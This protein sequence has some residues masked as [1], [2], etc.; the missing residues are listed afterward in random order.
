MNR[1]HA[2]TTSVVI[3]ALA[4][5]L[6]H[7]QGSGDSPREVR[8]RSGI[9]LVRIPA[10]SFEMGSNIRKAEQPIHR[11]TIREFWLGATEVTQAQWQAVMGDNPS[12]FT[13]AG[14]DAPVEM[15]T[16]DAAQVFVQKLG[17]IDPDWT[18]RLPSEAEWEYACRAG[19]NAE[20]YGPAQEVAWIREN[21]GGTTHPVGQKR[22]NAFG[23][24]DILG[25]VQE[26]VQDRWFE[27]HTGAPADGRAR[28]GGTSPLHPVKGGGWDLPEFFL[29]TALRDPLAPVHRLGLRVAAIPRKAAARLGSAP[30]LSIHEAERVQLLASE[31]QA[32]AQAEQ[33]NRAKDLFLATLS[34]ELRTPLSTMLMSAQILRQVA[35]EDPRIERASASIERSANAQARLIDELL[36]VS[37]IVSGKLLLD[38][39][40]VDLAVVVHEAV[41]GARPAAQAKSLMLEADIDDEIGAVY[42]DAS[43]L[44]QV[45]NNLLV[46]AI[47]FTPHDGRV[48][49]RLERLGD[50]R[51]Q[52]AV[53][54]TGVGIHPEVLP[55]VFSR[56]VQA[57]STVTR[58]HG[59]LGLGLA[60]VRHLVDVHGGEVRADSPGEGR[61]STFRVILPLGVAQGAQVNGVPTAVAREIRGV[62]VLLVEDDDDTREAYATMLA[63]L[64]ADVRSVASA[65][66]GL[67][68]LAEHRPQVIL[69]DIAMPGEDGFSFIQKVRRLEPDRGGRVPAAALTALASDEDRQRA[70]QSGFQLHVAKPIDPARLAAVVRV[71]AD[72]SPLGGGASSL[73][74]RDEAKVLGARRDRQTL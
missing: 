22:P 5:A 72:W 50:G 67:A 25:N 18:F 3:V 65:A 21:A 49:V 17:E 27:D 55:H 45:V 6:A 46:N 9:R 54:D 73:R 34:H 70:M 69:S 47:K 15:V 2:L 36:D 51:A 16:W 10:G 14:P 37:R 53:S 60:I 33:A 23:L 29:H 31:K 56:F 1:R 11:V 8:T 28:T 35:A 24:Y 57:D 19:E 13:E 12:H 68:A 61:G 64:G 52:L 40:P 39:G 7:A 4:C 66:A 59:G 63:E 32:R 42:G 62:S 30:Q 41:E 74:R 44:L 71:L 58:A 38:L 48:S 26:W 20:L 43:R